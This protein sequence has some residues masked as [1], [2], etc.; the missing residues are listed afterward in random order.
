MTQY[1]TGTE[2]VAIEIVNDDNMV[3]LRFYKAGT[4]LLLLSV[5]LQNE[6]GY[7]I[8]QKITMAAIRNE[9]AAK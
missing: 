2:D 4:N 8:A 1:F 3:K 5:A 7:K 6:A 9:E